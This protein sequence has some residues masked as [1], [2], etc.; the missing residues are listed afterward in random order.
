MSNLRKTIADNFKQ[1]YRTK[2]IGGDPSTDIIV[3][4]D[5]PLFVHA[6]DGSQIWIVGAIETVSKKKDLI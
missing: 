3:A 5:E 6:E 2:R 4:V 1:L